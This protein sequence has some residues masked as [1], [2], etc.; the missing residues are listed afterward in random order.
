MPPYDRQGIHNLQKINPN[1]AGVCP[2]FLIKLHSPYVSQKMGLAQRGV[3]SYSQ[4]S[5]LLV[6]TVR[7]RQHAQE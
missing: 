1:K 5:N 7:E 3:D 6:G 2:V 4:I